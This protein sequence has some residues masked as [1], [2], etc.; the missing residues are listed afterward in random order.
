MSQ[1]LSSYRQ[2]LLRKGQ[3]LSLACPFLKC[4]FCWI[5]CL[6]AWSRLHL[7][8]CSSTR[9][10]RCTLLSCRNLEA[11][12]RVAW[13]C[14]FPPDTNWQSCRTCWKPWGRSWGNWATHSHESSS[15]GTGAQRTSSSQRKLSKSEQVA[16]WKSKWLLPYSI[17]SSQSA[18]PR[19]ILKVLLLPR[20][21]ES[22]ECK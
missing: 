9:L 8:S 1:D 11:G 10:Q 21:S 18:C 19:S 17:E 22:S 5:F 2:D 14:K 12:V 16:Q 4:C 15:T 3:N 6:S 13:R 20:R 7:G